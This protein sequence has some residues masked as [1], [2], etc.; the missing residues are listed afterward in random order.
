VDDARARELMGALGDLLRYPGSGLAEAARRAA[1]LARGT[2]A[3]AALEGFAREAAGRP[4]AS[5]EE[6]YTATFDLDPACVPYVGHQ[7]L[8]ES[9]VRGALLAE[10]MGVYA[11]AGWA[12]REELGD[13]V[14]EVLSFLAVAPD[15]PERDDLVRDGLLPALEKMLE[16]LPDRGNPYRGLLE[17]AR[18]AAAAWASPRERGGA[19][20]RAGDGAAAREVRR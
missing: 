6:L 2:R 4:P 17:A 1:G 15:G 10:L 18:V 19:P 5:L 11:R 7:L 13:H 9:P 16:A 12:P 20:A 3:G 14:A 8:G